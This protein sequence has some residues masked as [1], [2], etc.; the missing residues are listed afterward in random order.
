M[1]LLLA[2]VA[3]AIACGGV[4]MVTALSRLARER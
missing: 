3:V 4:V 1:R 2:T